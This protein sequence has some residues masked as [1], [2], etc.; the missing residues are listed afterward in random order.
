MYIIAVVMIIFTILLVIRFFALL[1]QVGI[2]VLQFA[3]ELVLFVITAVRVLY[4]W[5]RT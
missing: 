1:L 4:V 3:Y 5:V 2:S